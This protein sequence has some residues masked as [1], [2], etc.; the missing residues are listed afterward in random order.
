MIFIKMYKINLHQERITSP[1]TLELF[2]PATWQLLKTD[3]FPLRLSNQPLTLFSDCTW[4]NGLRL[5]YA[6]L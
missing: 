3:F 4:Q 6:P 2:R 1:M 5:S